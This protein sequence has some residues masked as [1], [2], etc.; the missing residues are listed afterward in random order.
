MTQIVDDTTLRSNVAKRLI[1]RK[2]VFSAASLVGLVTIL[3][4]VQIYL[5]NNS[6]FVRGLGEILFELALLFI[7]IT[8]IFILLGFALPKSAKIFFTIGFILLISVFV[9]CGQLLFFSE[10]YLFDGSEIKID[11]SPLKVAVHTISIMLIGALI[12]WRR[13]FVFE[14]AALICTGLLI[15]PLL[16]TGVGIAKDSR[17]ILSAPENRTT[18]SSEFNPHELATKHNIIHVMFDSFQADF[19]SAMIREE[20]EI[21]AGL[22]GFE[23]FENYSGYSNWT[24]NSLLSILTGKDFYS[25]PFDASDQWKTAE[26][27][28]SENYLKVLSTLGYKVDFLG[29]TYLCSA[30][31]ITNC[32]RPFDLDTDYGGSTDTLLGFGSVSLVGESSLSLVDISLF[33]VV[34]IFLRAAV[35]NDGRFVVSNLV[36]KFSKNVFEES[37][38][39][40]DK[41]P[42][43]LNLYRTTYRSVS[44]FR[45]FVSRLTVGDSTHKYLFVHIYPPHRPFIFNRLCQLVPIDSANVNSRMG[46]SDPLRY[47]EHAGCALNLF[48]DLLRQ[49]KRLGVYDNSTIIFQSDTGLGISMMP[50]MSK[51][52][53]RTDIRDYDISTLI[54]Y[55]RPSMMIKRRAA[56]GPLKFRIDPATHANTFNSI[57]RIA[58][59]SPW[60]DRP[61]DFWSIPK[62]GHSRKFVVT[63][64]PLLSSSKFKAFEEYSISGDISD[65]SNWTKNGV[66][67]GYETIYNPEN[68]LINALDVKILDRGVAGFDLEAKAHGNDDAEYLFLAK[69]LAPNSAWR[70]IRSYSTTNRVNLTRDDTACG[71]LIH[72]HARGKRSI[73][74]SQVRKQL[75]IPARTDCL[76]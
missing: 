68:S 29:P 2:Y 71:M 7:S 27:L 49:L 64:L 76:Q 31:E 22:D 48:R 6:E 58:G 37:S 36:R 13:K 60:S 54:G 70:S 44:A 34:P 18:I 53:L 73:S 21:M 50:E 51:G 17:S 19:L 75:T 55:A 15:W 43:P 38:R 1:W 26:A 63:D 25:A 45:Q 35:Y 32:R 30:I 61:A 42:G 10:S 72:V 24:A 65:F 9:F 40:L 69:S 39:D 12:C 57:M 5:Q 11:S 67:S 3:L 28:Y 23:V 46:D 47:K 41:F 66:F 52:E 33:R 4:P 8:F 59:A 62:R 56:K 20:S 16:S 74:G 14:H